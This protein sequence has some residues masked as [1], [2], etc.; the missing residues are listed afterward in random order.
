MSSFGT[1]EGTGAG[2]TVTVTCNSA[3]GSGFRPRYKVIKRLDGTGSWWAQ[4]VFTHIDGTNTQ[5]S[6]NFNKNFMK[7]ENSNGAFESAAHCVI[8]DTATGFKIHTQ[9]ALSGLPNG[10][11]DTFIY[12]AFA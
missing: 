11:T 3:G 7:L 10:D 5:V 4:D 6:G 2:T 12:W 9:T 1:F 8:E